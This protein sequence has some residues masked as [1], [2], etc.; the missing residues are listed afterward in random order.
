MKIDNRASNKTYV[1]KIKRGIDS[2]SGEE[3]YFVNLPQELVEQFGWKEET[4]LKVEVK[5]G[6]NGNVLVISET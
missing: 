3:F 6:P 1:E 2:D 5:L 4:E